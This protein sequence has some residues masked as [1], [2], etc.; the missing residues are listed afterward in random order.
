MFFWIR[1]I[2]GW[3]L[4]AVGLYLVRLVVTFVSDPAEARIV[5]AGVVMFCALGLMRAGILLIRVSTAARIT[6]KDEV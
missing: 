1:E 6:L 5:E 2:A 3:L 4:V